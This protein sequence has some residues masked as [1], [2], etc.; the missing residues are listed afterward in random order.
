MNALEPNESVEIL[1]PLL[2]DEHQAFDEDLPS[3]FTLRF[4]SSSDGAELYTQSFKMKMGY[5]MG[6]FENA[7]PKR[8]ILILHE[9][10]RILKVPAP[11]NIMIVG[12]DGIGKTSLAERI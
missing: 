9:N 11:I 8:E 4:T 10:N 7:I 5:Y 3:H 6:D 2:Y 12:Q 1:L